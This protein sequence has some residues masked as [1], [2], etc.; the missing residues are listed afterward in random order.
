MAWQLTT[1]GLYGHLTRPQVNELAVQERFAALR[2]LLPEELAQD[3][4]EW[5][6]SVRGEPELIRPSDEDSTYW[7]KRQ[8]E[9]REAWEDHFTTEEL[10]DQRS[11][12][13]ERRKAAQS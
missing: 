2:K 8:E 13:R 12:A 9:A 4:N 5:E 3:F 10:K 6:I 7:R 1:I 11:R